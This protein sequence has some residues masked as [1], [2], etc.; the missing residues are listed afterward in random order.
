MTACRHM[1]VAA[2]PPAVEA[3]TDL[4]QAHRDGVSILD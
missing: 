2:W 1:K 3:I 4:V